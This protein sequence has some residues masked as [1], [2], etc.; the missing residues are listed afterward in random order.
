APGQPVSRPPDGDAVPAATNP[1]G[2]AAG[3][4]ERGS[5]APA[6][7]A[8]AAG[9]NSVYRIA[10]D[11][12]ARELFRDRK[13]VLGLDRHAGRL[14]VG[15]GLDGR[16]FEID[17]AT[18]ER[19]EIARLDHGLVHKVY[20]RRDGSAVV[21][22]GD[23]GRLYVLQDGYAASGTV[24]SEVLDAKLTA[25]WGALRWEA[26]VP[27]D[28]HLSVAVRSG[29]VAEPDDTWSAWS[30]E[31]TD[32]QTATVAAPPARYLQYRVTLATEDAA[33]TPTLRRL[34][35]RY[36]TANQAPEITAL[37]VP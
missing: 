13:L 22:A 8:P 16:L 20:R 32:A 24:V 11:G 5:P 34:S 2:G 1:G 26:D 37:T 4:T 19:T 7:S 35:V 9:E 17:E 29:N 33:A 31:Q 27:K 23:P 10:A 6:P 15:T 3:S 18:R 30:A 28:T 12:S 25:R 14:F 36:A 21:A